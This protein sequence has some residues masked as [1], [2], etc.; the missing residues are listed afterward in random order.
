MQQTLAGTVLEPEDDGGFTVRVP[1]LPEIVTYGGDEREALAMAEDA[2]GMPSSRT[3][4]RA[5]NLFLKASLRAFARPPVAEIR[6]LRIIDQNLARE[7]VGNSGRE[8]RVAVEL[9]MR[10][11]GGIERQLRRSPAGPIRRRTMSGNSGA[12]NG[13]TVRRKWSR[14]TSCGGRSSHGTSVRSP[15]QNFPIR[16]K[17]GGTQVTPK[18][19]I[20]TTLRRGCLV[21]TPSAIRLTTCD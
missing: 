18:D 14:K 15:R 19:K 7:I 11:V 5:A 13:C 17:N 12:S 10:I 8:E 1:S 2:T 21:N 3:V 16:H 6:R 9:P 20:S 4:W